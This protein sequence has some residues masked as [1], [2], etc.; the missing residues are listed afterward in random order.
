M[1]TLLGHIERWLAYSQAPLEDCAGEKEM[2]DKE[3]RK[4]Y[5]QNNQEKSIKY[6]IQWN[7][8][9]KEKKKE[10]DKKWYERGS[11]HFTN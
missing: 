10:Y 2:T 11:P 5:Y 1:Q 8:D 6:S 3:Y 9:N 4:K 7:K